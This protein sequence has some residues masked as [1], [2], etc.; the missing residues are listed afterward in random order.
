ML[1]CHIYL[2]WASDSALKTQG[3][4]ASPLNCHRHTGHKT[5]S[6]KPNLLCDKTPSALQEIRGD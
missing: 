4:K 1:H 3:E 6:Y 5:A 2:H